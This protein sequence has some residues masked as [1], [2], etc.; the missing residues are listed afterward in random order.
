[1]TFCSISHFLANHSRNCNHKNAIFNA[2]TKMQI[3]TSY[4]TNVQ[5]IPTNDKF[6]RKVIVMTPCVVSATF[7][8]SHSHIY[9]SRKNATFIAATRMQ[10]STPYS[11]NVQ[12]IHNNDKWWMMWSKINEKCTAPECIRALVRLFCSI[13]D[14]NALG[15]QPT[16]YD[17]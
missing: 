2:A 9:S 3:S 14:F 7:L 8:S 16:L 10:I 12:S 13:N 4:S 6:F 15:R 1:M 5:S 17:Q 11:K